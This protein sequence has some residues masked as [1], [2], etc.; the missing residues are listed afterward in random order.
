MLHRS[1][2]EAAA[3]PLPNCSMLPVPPPNFQRVRLWGLGRKNQ[4]TASFPSRYLIS[5]V[6]LQLQASSSPLR[7][8]RSHF[9][10]LHA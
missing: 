1:I 6:C 2:V 3:A 4:L 9:R 5:I 7:G 10:V 8:A